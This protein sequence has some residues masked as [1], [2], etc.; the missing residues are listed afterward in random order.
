[1]AGFLGPRLSRLSLS[2]VKQHLPSRAVSSSS[3][4]LSSKLSAASPD[5]PRP[6]S[7]IPRKKGFLKYWDWLGPRPEN[8]TIKRFKELGHIYRESLPSSGFPEFVVVCDPEDI[9]KVIRADGRWPLRDAMPLWSELREKL[10]LPKGLFLLNYEE[11]YN[12]RKPM[13]QFMMVPFKVQEHAPVFNEI[14]DDLIKAIREQRHHD[15]RVLSDVPKLFFNW[16]FE[17]VAY[18]VL[19]KRLGALDLDNVPKDCQEF[20]SALQEFFAAT[21]DLLFSNPLKKL[22]P[23]KALS[24]LKETQIKIYQLSLNYI[25][26]RI[27]EIK[28]REEEGK[29]EPDDKRPDF[30][31]YMIE[32]SGMTLEQISVNAQDLLGAGVDTTSY[33]LAW[34]LYCLGTNPDVQDRLREE[35]NRVVGDSTVITPHH[36]HHL[37]Y[38]RSCFKESLRLYPI[39]ANNIRILNKDIVLSG[40]ELP[41]G[42]TVLMPTYAMGRLPHV[43]NDPLSF[44]PERWEKGDDPTQ[45]VPRFASLPFGSGPRMCVGRRVAE[46]ELHI[47]LARIIGSF[48]VSYTEKTPMEIA[49]KF[50]LVPKTS[51]NLKFED[52]K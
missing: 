23:T 30:M 50:L 22:F 13:S 43:F 5:I 33:T 2:S 34:C 26:D 7:E 24:S 38:L 36:I 37:P 48:N 19:G 35:V 16:S 25:S 41:Q 11:W 28:E 8:V 20:I 39:A 1:M 51:L 10:N 9:E 42:T 27:R 47:A 32:N 49:L 40:Y 18:F 46:L 31:T 3:Y 15:T 17:S 29:E 4:I 14:T 45:E 12:Q 21:Q 44:K 6:F 52:I